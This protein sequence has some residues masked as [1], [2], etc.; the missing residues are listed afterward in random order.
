[1]NNERHKCPN[2]KEKMVEWH[3]GVMM[4]YICHVCDIAECAN[5]LVNPGE[6]HWSDG[7][8]TPCESCKGTGFIKTDE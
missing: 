1:M 5:C 8:I 7:Q 4:P 3:K 6:S 2:C